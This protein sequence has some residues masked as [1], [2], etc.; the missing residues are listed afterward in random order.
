MHFSCCVLFHNYAASMGTSYA[1]FIEFLTHWT[2]CTNEMPER[3]PC[4]FF[5]QKRPPLGGGTRGQATRGTC[6]LRQSRHGGA[7][8]AKP[9]ML[10]GR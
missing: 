1:H 6:R 5:C 8:N 4:E 7:A 9:G 3:T 2:T 10:L